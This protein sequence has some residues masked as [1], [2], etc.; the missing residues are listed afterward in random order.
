MDFTWA[1]LQ[2]SIGKRVRRH[3]WP[4]QKIEAGAKRSADG[5]PYDVEKTIVRQ[6]HLWVMDGY[7]GR[8]FWRSGIINGWGGSVGGAADDDS[9]RDGMLYSA[10]NEDMTADDW[11]LMQRL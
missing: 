6:W 2:L 3:C 8:D 10:T 5:V 4:I 1:L 9:V 7:K 11:E